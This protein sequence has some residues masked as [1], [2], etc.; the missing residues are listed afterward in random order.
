MREANF[1]RTRDFVGMIVAS[2]PVDEGVCRVAVMTFS[3]DAKV[4]FDLA[5][6]KSR[7]S[8]TE[9]IEKITYS[10]GTTNTA[11]ALQLAR[12]V[13][14]SERGDRVGVTNIIVLFTDGGSN[15]IADTLKE[16][17]S[18]KLHGITILVVAIGTWVNRLE[19]LSIASF[20]SADNTFFLKSFDALT[21]ILDRLRM[22]VCN[23]KCTDDRYP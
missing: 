7:N 23:G 13:F 11:A 18:T 8:S 21:S 15:N 17:R 16:A 6:H 20:P 19:V 3:N 4:Q 2:L 9:A 5:Q 10:V 12:T 14:Q 1:Q 22:S